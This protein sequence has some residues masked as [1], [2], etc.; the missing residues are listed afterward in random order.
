MDSLSLAQAR[1]IILHSQLLPP[2]QVKQ[3]SK[4][5]TLSALEQLGYIQIDTIS[6]IQ[7][8][9]HHTLW[10]RN[11]RYQPKDLDVL[12]EI[13]NVLEGRTVEAKMLCQEILE[14]TQSVEVK[15]PLVN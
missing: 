15:G 12:L 8:A 5:V 14:L 6:V 13:L 10:N 7:R 11:A 2:K 1:K 4:A 3:S 9:H